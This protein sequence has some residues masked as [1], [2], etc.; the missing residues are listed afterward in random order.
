MNMICKKTWK[1]KHIFP[2]CASIFLYNQNHMT[3]IKRYD[4]QLYFFLLVLKP[5]K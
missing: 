4:H 5:H 3:Y 1:M 2:L